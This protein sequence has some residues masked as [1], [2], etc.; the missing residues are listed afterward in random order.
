M[1]VT[2][3][4]TYN[5]M[6]RLLELIVLAREPTA[7]GVVAVV[8][9]ARSTFLRRKP[10]GVSEVLTTVRSI[11]ENLGGRILCLR[12]IGSASEPQTQLC[13]LKRIVPMDKS[14]RRSVAEQHNENRGHR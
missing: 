4:Q 6:K 11:I 2:D 5:V 1:L 3:D 14:S 9:E 12:R 13:P 7:I 10:R 8:P